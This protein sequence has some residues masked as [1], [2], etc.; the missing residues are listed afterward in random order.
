[1]EIE[2]EKEGKRD[3]GRARMGKEHFS[4]FNQLQVNTW[5]RSIKQKK[6][7]SV[8]ISL[9]VSVCKWYLCSFIFLGQFRWNSTFLLQICQYRWRPTLPS[10]GSS[11]L[12]DKSIKLKMTT[13]CKNNGKVTR[14]QIFYWMSWCSL[15]LMHIVT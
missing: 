1:M 9:S 13:F 3:G 2:R 7:V 14:E 15:L 4:G 12:A 8:C 5:F 10:P 6:S 11:G